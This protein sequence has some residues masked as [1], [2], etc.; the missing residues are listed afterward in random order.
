MAFLIFCFS[1]MTMLLGFYDL[2]KNIPRLREALYSVFGDLFEEFENAIVLRLSVL[3][4][5]VLASSQYFQNLITIL[6][7]PFETIWY[8]CDWVLLPIRALIWTI[9]PIVQLLLFI[10]IQFKD[11]IFITLTL[12]FD[13]V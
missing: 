9:H 7:G 3:L 11:F 5:Y 4:G 12:P 8:F 2:Y 10:M 13:I 6:I 1:L